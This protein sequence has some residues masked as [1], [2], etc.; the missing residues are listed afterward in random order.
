LRRSSRDFS[1]VHITTV[2]PPFD[3]RIFHREC[4]S[5]AADGFRTTLIAYAGAETNR[6]DVR[7]ISLGLPQHEY[8]RLALWRRA[9]RARAALKVALREKADVYH[10]HDPELISVAIAL[11]RTTGARVIYD[12]HEDNVGYALQKPYI[13]RILRRA[14]AAAVSLYERRAAKRLDAVVTADDGVRQ[15]FEAFGARAVTVHNFPRLEF[16]DQPW[17][18]PKA[19]DL[20]YHGSLPSYHLRECFAIDHALRRRGRHVRWLLFGRFA[21][22][23]WARAE[24]AAQGAADRFIFEGPVPHEEVARKVSTA[25]IGIIPLPDLP[26]FRHNIP[27]KLFEFM[28]LGLPVVLSDLPPSR[29]FIGDGCCALTVP[30]SDAAGFADAII[31]L[32]DQPSLCREMGEEGRRRVARLYNWKLESAKL[33]A[34]YRTLLE[35]QDCPSY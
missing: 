26:K 4:V 30:A 15:R 9:R 11:K 29:P 33:I 5:L 6:D 12:C 3:Q 22:I 25:R 7:L 32:L 27:T 17:A 34:L 2:H 16:F 10:I 24:A 23:G 31:R 19:V 1:V 13:P 14:V 35:G 18:T 20:V 8:G 21:D 28:A